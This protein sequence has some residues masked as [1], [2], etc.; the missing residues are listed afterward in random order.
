MKTEEPGYTPYTEVEAVGARVGFV[1]CL[2]CGA[3]L[4]LDPRDAKEQWVNIRAIHDAWHG[5]VQTPVKV[6]ARKV[7]K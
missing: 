7:R 2:M 1:S 3:C 6:A 4:L 5:H